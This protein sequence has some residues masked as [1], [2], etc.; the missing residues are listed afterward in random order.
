MGGVALLILLSSAMI[1]LWRSMARL[2]PPPPAEPPRRVT[3]DKEEEEEEA[4]SMER[5]V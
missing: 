2:P 4:W 1:G 5:G 3:G